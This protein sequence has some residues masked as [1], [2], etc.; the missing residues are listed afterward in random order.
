LKQGSYGSHQVIGK[1]LYV[2]DCKHSRILF[3][4]KC[5]IPWRN[6]EESGIGLA[7]SAKTYIQNV[8]P[9]VE[10]LFGKD[11]KPIKTSMSEGYHPEVD[12]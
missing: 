1:D 2:K 11:I 8:I 5:G 6:M 12:D 7:L 9:R 4:W 3:R 10:G